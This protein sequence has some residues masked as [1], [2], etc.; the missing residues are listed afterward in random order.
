[1][2]ETTVRAA[3]TVANDAPGRATLLESTGPTGWTLTPGQGTEQERAQKMATDA[4][5]NVVSGSKWTDDPDIGT[6]RI[7]IERVNKA[8]PRPGDEDFRKQGDEG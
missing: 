4:G 7:L 3:L 2:T 5:W 1:M 8:N 6:S